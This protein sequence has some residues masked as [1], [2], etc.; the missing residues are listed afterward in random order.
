[1]CSN[2][3]S[4]PYVVL[5]YATSSPVCFLLWI[6]GL[7]L[8]ALSGVKCGQLQSNRALNKLAVLF[9]VRL[10]QP[11]DLSPTPSS[12]SDSMAPT[13]SSDSLSSHP[14]RLLCVC[15]SVCASV[16]AHVCMCLWKAGAV[17][18]IHPRAP[19]NLFVELSQNQRHM[20]CVCVRT[21]DMRVVCG[22]CM[23]V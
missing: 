6:I 17:F 3:G 12:E 10:C 13:L 11:S 22:V 4:S 16:C 19:I 18:G 15:A 8:A 1:M 20:V 14:T 5:S 7:D 21:C 2:P 9:C 23:C